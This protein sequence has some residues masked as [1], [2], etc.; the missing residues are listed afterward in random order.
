MIRIHNSGTNICKL[1]TKLLCRGVYFCIRKT[2]NK[3]SDMRKILFTSMLLL[4]TLSVTACGGTENDPLPPE[5]PEQPGN[6]DEGGDEPDTPTTGG[7]GRYLVLYS[8]RTSNTERMAQQ[9]QSTL[10]C[11]ILE[12]EPQTAYERDYNAMLDRAQTELAAIRQGNY[13]P[14]RTSVESF[15]QYELIFVGYPIWYGSIATP[16]QTFLHQHAA[17]LSGKR[18]ALFATSGS[19]G[20]SSSVNEARALC[21]DATFTETLLLTSSTLSQMTNRVATWLESLGANRE[22]NNPTSMTILSRP[23]SAYDD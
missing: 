15:D 4:T 16:M 7:N 21:P 14:I 23:R 5:I 8:S 2:I 17:R 10:D 9:I 22:E 11:D 13:P 3:N 18:I 6:P 1:Y 20:M 19:S 12:V